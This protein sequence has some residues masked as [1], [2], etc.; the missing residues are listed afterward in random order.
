MRATAF[1]DTVGRFQV[2]FIVFDELLIRR[3]P[4]R[5][6]GPGEM[7][8]LITSLH[9]TGDRSALQREPFSRQRE[10]ERVRE[11]NKERERE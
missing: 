1:Y 2:V 9:T 10:R 6:H 8:R 3:C 5:A 7:H 4:G 11:S